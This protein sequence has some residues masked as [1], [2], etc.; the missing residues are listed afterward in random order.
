MAVSF[1]TQVVV[2]QVT[3]YHTIITTTS[4]ILFHILKKILS[5]YLNKR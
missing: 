2:N 5:V 4:P 3:G 1:I